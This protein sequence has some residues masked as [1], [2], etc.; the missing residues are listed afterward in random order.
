MSQ[1][2]EAVKALTGVDLTEALKKLT[3]I[4][5]DNGQPADATNKPEGGRK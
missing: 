3:K 5:G 4:G 2:P 1:M